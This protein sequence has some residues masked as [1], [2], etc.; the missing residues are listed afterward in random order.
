MA[1]RAHAQRRAGGALA[2]I[3]LPLPDDAYAA[4]VAP[5]AARHGRVRGPR[6]PAERPRRRWCAR[7]RC[8]VPERRPRR[9][10]ARRRARAAASA[11]GRRAARRRARRA[12][13]RRAAGR[14]RGDRR[15]R[16]RRAA[17]ALGGA[18][19]LRGD[20]SVRARAHRRR[21]RHGRRPR[22]ARRRHERR[23]GSRPATR[24]RCPPRS[25]RCS[26]TT[27]AA[28][29]FGRRAREDAERF[30]AAQVARR[31][32]QRVP[33][34]LTSRGDPSE[35]DRVLAVPRRRRRLSKRCARAAPRSFA[36]SIATTTRPYGSQRHVEVG[37]A[38]YSATKLSSASTR[39][40]V[41]SGVAGGHAARARLRSAGRSA[42]SPCLD[43]IRTV[44][45]HRCPA[46]AATSAPQ[47]DARGAAR[48]DA[49]CTVFTPVNSRSRHGW[50]S[51]TAGARAS[52][53]ASDRSSVS[54]SQRAALVALGAAHRARATP[55]R[56][57]R[58]RRA[59]RTTT[60]SSRL[61]R[62]AAHRGRGR[63]RHGVRHDDRSVA[64]A[65]AGGY[66]GA[67]L[68]PL[69]V[70]LP[71]TRRSTCWSRSS[72]TTLETARRGAARRRRRRVAAGYFRTT[73]CASAR[74]SRAC[75]TST[76]RRTAAPNDGWVAV[77]GTKYPQARCARPRHCAKR[78][79]RAGKEGSARHRGS[80]YGGTAP[81]LS[82]REDT[83]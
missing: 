19:R 68:I 7:S 14:A 81:S 60:R 6:R 79:S 56:R 26:T 80:G 82:T 43:R 42:P 45:A 63:Q 32:A 51:R 27:S 77:D 12:G 71:A 62:G 18:V 11:R 36:P 33:A 20:R 69:R 10:R 50:G 44:R 74:S 52:R 16:A 73:R 53:R 8:I 30:R 64:P 54:P 22:V 41:T 23:R 24:A 48:G 37:V 1:E 67:Q 49:A 39:T 4:A 65:A 2:E 13:R 75:T 34:A 55:C 25:T 61:H 5:S 72:P 15:R 9:A 40:A 59:R 29:G 47:L 78:N 38:S 76:A 35:V 3:P 17:V 28:R 70:P 58:A 57:A 66:G 83:R 31:A 46:A 21:V